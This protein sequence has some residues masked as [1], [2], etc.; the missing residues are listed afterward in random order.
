ML[1]YCGIV[2][3]DLEGM[4]LKWKSEWK[5]ILHQN[6]NVPLC[7][8]GALTNDLSFDKN[9][10]GRFPFWSEGLQCYNPQI[11][12]EMWSQQTTAYFYI[13]GQCMMNKLGP[14]EVSGAFELS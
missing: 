9:L 13:F 14:S 8:D 3:L 11:Q 5:H 1:I 2:L 10:D 7:I 4:S 6:L 12:F